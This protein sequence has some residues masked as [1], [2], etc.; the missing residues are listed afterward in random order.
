MASLKLNAFIYNNLSVQDRLNFGNKVP[1][2]K[3]KEKQMRESYLSYIIY[4]IVG[5]RAIVHCVSKYH[6]ECK[7]AFGGTQISCRLLF[8]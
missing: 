2:K 8:H 3:L 1:D 6:L 4:L 7:A 5:S